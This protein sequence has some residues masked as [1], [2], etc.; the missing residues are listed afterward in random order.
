MESPDPKKGAN[1]G[2][3]ANVLRMA[4]EFLHSVDQDH[5]FVELVTDAIAPGYSKVVAQ[6]MAISLLR[7]KISKNFYKNLESLNAD[8]QLIHKNC[9][10]YNGS[11][12]PFSKVHLAR[13]LSI[14]SHNLSRLR[15]HSSL[16]GVC[17]TCCSGT[18]FL[19]W[20]RIQTRSYL[21]LRSRNGSSRQKERTKLQ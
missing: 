4:V 11:Q 20:P 6:P 18:S 21:S 15:R 3:L 7:N 13:I 1:I 16:N 9:M 10:R 17:S 2:T 12:S 19:S 5:F 8:V 14:N